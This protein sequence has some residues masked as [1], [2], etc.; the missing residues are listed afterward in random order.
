MFEYNMY[1]L[2]RKYQKR[3]A[4]VEDN[5]KRFIQ[6]KLRDYG[7]Y[8]T[9]RLNNNYTDI[10]GHISHNSWELEKVKTKAM[11]EGDDKRVAEVTRYF[12]RSENFLTELRNFT[13]GMMSQNFEGIDK[14]YLTF[15]YVPLTEEVVCKL[16]VK[17]QNDYL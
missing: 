2:L 11:L 7:D 9:T 15:N 5:V 17:I 12:R 16:E 13:E 3:K 10:R 8:T 14:Y 4:K 6:E 1:K